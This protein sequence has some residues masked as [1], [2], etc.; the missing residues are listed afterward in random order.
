MR[1]RFIFL[2]IIVCLCTVNTHAGTIYIQ[3]A[4]MAFLRQSEDNVHWQLVLY[5]VDARMTHFSGAD[6]SQGQI[7]SVKE[8]KN[9][10][11]HQN[12]N[13]PLQLKGTLVGYWLSKRRPHQVRSFKLKL[14]KP[15]YVARR[16]EITYRVKVISPKQPIKPTRFHLKDPTLLIK[17]P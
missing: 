10:Q 1:S 14:S 6:F 8:F 7:I 12:H 15:K 13:G 16:S 11:L 4:S 3:C 17:R 5:D 2:C 9:K